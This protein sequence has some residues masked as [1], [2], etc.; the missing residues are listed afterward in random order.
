MSGSS[1][2]GIQIVETGIP[3]LGSQSLLMVAACLLMVRRC[4]LSC[5]SYYSDI[6]QRVRLKRR[7][8]FVWK[9]LMTIRVDFQRD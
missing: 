3:E 5:E 1:N 2:S 8:L 9:I 6:F 7:A 4:R